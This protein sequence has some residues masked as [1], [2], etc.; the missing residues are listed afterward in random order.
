M[1]Q[2]LVEYSKAEP[3]R[4]G[5]HLVVLLH[6]YGSHERD[7]LGLTPY[8]PS[9]KVTYASVRAPQP[10]GYQLPADAGSAYVQGTAM[11]YQWWPLNQQ[12][13]TVGFTAIELAVD[14]LLGWLEPIAADYESVTLLG[15][16]Q[17]MALATS[18]ARA[19]PDLI[20]AVVGL[21]GY[22]VAGGEHYF[23]DAQLAATP[24]PLFWGRDEADPIITPDKITYTQEWVADHTALTAQTYPNIGHGVAAAE[25]THVAGFLKEK[26]L[27]A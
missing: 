9:E 22:A 6:G 12:L 19:R 7:L 25:L 23:K 4:R 8:L 18:V 21:S 26:V 15:F 5:T 2:Y 1:N 17:G 16:S 27:S 14:Y 11:G 13:E 3:F 24:L 20:K 10:V